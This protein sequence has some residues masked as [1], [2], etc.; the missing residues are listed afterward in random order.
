[1]KRIFVFVIVLA[2]TFSMFTF[3]ET[4]SDEEIATELN[5][6]NL[7]SGDDTGFNLDGKLTRAEAATF[8][9]KLLGQEEEVQ[10]RKAL[11]VRSNFP[12]IKGDEWYAP[13]V[14]FCERNYI[15]SGYP[16]G[17]V[18]A[19]EPL[20]EK[21]FFTMVLKGLGYDESD[22]TWD[23]VNSFAYEVGLINDS[24]Y[25]D[26]TSDNTSYLRSGVVNVMYNSLN[27]SYKEEEKTVISNLIS[28]G[29]AS[30]TVVDEFDLVKVDEVEMA[31]KSIDVKSK[32]EVK[33]E[34]TEDAQII[35]DDMIKLVDKN[36][37]ALQFSLTN[38][39]S[40]SFVLETEE[41]TANTKYNLLI[42]NL[43]DNQNYRY[44]ET[45][46]SF[47]G[48]ED[49]VIV[50]NYF[51]ISKIVPVSI[52]RIDVYFTHPINSSAILPL[53]YSIYDGDTEFVKGGFS[54]LETSLVAGTNNALSIK[55]KTGKFD[56]NTV[57]TL[58]AKGTTVSA[59]SS[60][61]NNGKDLNKEFGVSVMPNTPMNIV[62]VQ[63]V[64]E[65]HVRLEF[66]KPV[67]KSIAQNTSNYRLKDVTNNL[68]YPAAF[69]ITVTG[70]GEFEDKYV[71][72]KWLTFTKDRNYEMTVKNL[73]DSLNSS[74]ISETV[75]PFVGQDFSEN[76][77]KVDYAVA[78]NSNLITVYFN[79]PLH[80]DSV[81]AVVTGV[82]KQ[83]MTFDPENPYQLK[84]YVNSS[85]G[86]VTGSEYNLNFV[87]GLKDIYGKTYINV[88]YKVQ[89]VTY[90]YPDVIIESAVAISKNQIKVV[91]DKEISQTTSAA[92]FVLEYTNSEN[93]QSTIATQAIS[94]YDKKTAILTYSNDFDQNYYVLKASN[95]ADFSNQFTTTSTNTDVIVE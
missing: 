89:G 11:Y 83:A 60:K 62:N 43:K 13:Y 23:T 80:S 32:T 78:E 30:Q 53:N 74:T 72:V 8:I 27:L 38:V 14:G 85:A 46:K 33:V 54:T 65:N 71:D 50:S 21:A 44:K 52:D 58:R 40:N 93:K 57:Y 20:S 26:K 15:M 87:T 22:F 45:T 47:T 5:A 69:G 56:E 37:E 55:L 1:M 51:V 92:K 25:E 3:A 34:L 36:D 42:S 95:I 16:D 79:R 35:T 70:E 76:P 12:D 94:F 49:P 18:K 64:N 2:L 24:S 39:T 10:A 84:I 28:E 86:L 59:Y 90:S 61:L 91:F 63:Q 41:Q 9:V 67:D 6:I 82:S 29:I 4:K 17:E 48:Y 68:E 73:Q 31:I 19:L 81:N 88:A 77:F 66:D 75:Y 7:I